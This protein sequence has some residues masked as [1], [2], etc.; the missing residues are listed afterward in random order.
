MEMASKR[1]EGEKKSKHK[2]KVEKEREVM[3]H[4]AEDNETQS[5]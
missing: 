4:R 1:E 2:K 3:F 5:G